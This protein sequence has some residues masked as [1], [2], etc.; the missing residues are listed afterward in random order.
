MSFRSHQ[1]VVAMKPVQRVVD[2]RG[3]P[4]FLPRRTLGHPPAC[5]MPLLID[6]E[7]CADTFVTDMSR[8]AE[9]YITV[10]RRPGVSPSAA[11]NCS[12]GMTVGAIEAKSDTAQCFNFRRIER[13]EAIAANVPDCKEVMPQYESFQ[14]PDTSAQA[15]FVVALIGL[16]I[17]VLAL[18]VLGGVLL[19]RWSRR[20]A[21]KAKDLDLDF[22]GVNP[23]ASDT[24]ALQEAAADRPSPDSAAG[25]QGAVVVDVEP[26]E[27]RDEDE[28]RRKQRQARTREDRQRLE[29]RIMQIEDGVD[30]EGEDEGELGANAGVLQGRSSAATMQLKQGRGGSKLVMG[31]VRSSKNGASSSASDRPGSGSSGSGSGGRSS[32]ADELYRS[33]LTG[34]K[35]P[36]SPG[37]SRV[38]TP[39]EGAQGPRGAA[40]RRMPGSRGSAVAGEDIDLSVKRRPDTAS[41][42]G[43]AVEMDD[44]GIRIDDILAQARG[45]AAAA[46]AGKTT[47]DRS[48]AWK[49]G[50]RSPAPSGSGSSG[51][52]ADGSGSSSSREGT[53]VGGASREPAPPAP[54][55]T[56]GADGR[57]ARPPVMAPLMAARLGIKPQQAIGGR[58][59]AP[60]G[61]KP[62]QATS[63]DKTEPSPTTAKRTVMLQSI[64][65]RAVANLPVA[66]TAGVPLPP[67]RNGAMLPPSRAL[68]GN[69][70][71]MARQGETEAQR[72]SEAGPAGLP[73][74]GGNAP[75]WRTPTGTPEA[76]AQRPPLGAMS[77]LPG[78]GAGANGRDGRGMNR[79]SVG[80]GR[81]RDRDRG[82]PHEHVLEESD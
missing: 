50:D 81:G 4:P 36:G 21:R 57:P 3:S 37:G 60:L 46:A 2:C 62:T 28:P 27:A 49:A 18:L 66:G 12:F 54:S 5:R 58:T 39:P 25:D 53:S 63:P 68:P 65:P 72:A 11:S 20:K 51:A 33:R 59:M 47:P 70:N 79:I 45:A 56:A 71:G 34:R 19:R 6:R 8:K 7:M 24:L 52:K 23:G 42:A 26:A 67:P 16:G 55:A 31:S 77:A 64:A 35:L 17:L 14:Q 73:P 1:N 22:G 15:T 80:N 76:G 44:T 30:D 29:R 74:V 9:F 48:R 43:S 41:S 10:Q 75:A 13:G 78:Q 82:A 38:P 61:S 32:P 40:P 69:G